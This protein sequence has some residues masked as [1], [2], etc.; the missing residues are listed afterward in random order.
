MAVIC[1]F[2]NLQKVITDAHLIG[3]RI[4][5]SMT[6]NDADLGTNSIPHLP[7]KIHRRVVTKI[8]AFH[9]YFLITR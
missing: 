6:I 8:L 9:I 7:L 3:T 1:S 4:I 2:K 5:A